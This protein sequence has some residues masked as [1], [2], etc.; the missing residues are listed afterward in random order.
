VRE[1]GKILRKIDPHL[2]DVEIRSTSACAKCGVCHFNQSGLLSME[3]KNDIG[4]SVGDAV[5]I[6]IPEGRVILSSLM[7]FIF[8]I[9][10]FFAGYLIKGLVLGAAVLI[11]YLIFLYL[12]DKRTKTIPRIA[13]ILSNR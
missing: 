2:A 5:E 12:Y 13:R 7:I 6:E 3:A 1:T 4:A 9:I 8:P 11:A 10:A